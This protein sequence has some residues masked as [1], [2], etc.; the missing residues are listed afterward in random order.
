MVLDNSSPQI[1]VLRPHAVSPR[2]FFTALGYLSH[3]RPGGPQSNDQKPLVSPG[4]PDAAYAEAGASLSYG[5]LS[6]HGKASLPSLVVNRLS[7]R[8]PDVT[9]C[10]E[11]TF[12]GGL[13]ARC[14]SRKCQSPKTYWRF[15]AYNYFLVGFRS[16]LN[17]LRAGRRGRKGTTN[18]A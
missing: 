2:C 1:R 10:R 13:S 7:R 6:T 11:N 4:G 16:K 5:F 15:F 17:C 8:M 3:G 18:V 9:E 14:S 12:A